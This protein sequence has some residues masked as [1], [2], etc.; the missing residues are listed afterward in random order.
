MVSKKGK[1]RQYMAGRYECDA[2]TAFAVS[3]SSA[4]LAKLYYGMGDFVWRAESVRINCGVFS[5][6]TPC[7]Y[8]FRYTE[9]YDR[10]FDLRKRADRI[11]NHGGYHF[12]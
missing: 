12:V 7:K 9:R 8:R 6:L 10:R 4:L 3:G 5:S 2:H 11:S 1:S